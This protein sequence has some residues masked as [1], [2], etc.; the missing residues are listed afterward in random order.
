MTDPTVPYATH[1]VSRALQGFDR[2]WD[3][4]ILLRALVLS[5]GL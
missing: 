1:F 5:G 2:D 4:R 3:E